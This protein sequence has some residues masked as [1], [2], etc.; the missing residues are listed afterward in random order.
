M[1]IA[2]WLSVCK[3]LLK[4]EIS[5]QGMVGHI[6]RRIHL[7]EKP[8]LNK[9]IGS[10]LL[11]EPSMFCIKRDPRSFTHFFS[12]LP[13][14]GRI[15]SIKYGDMKWPAKA[16]SETLKAAMSYVTYGNTESGDID[17]EPDGTL[18]RKGA[19]T[20]FEM[21]TSKDGRLLE[22]RQMK[23]GYAPLSDTEGFG[24][25]WMAL[26]E[27][28]DAEVISSGDVDSVLDAVLQEKLLTKSGKSLIRQ[29]AKSRFRDGK[30]HWHRS[31]GDHTFLE[32]FLKW[33]IK[34]FPKVM[35]VFA[36]VELYE[37]KKDGHTWKGLAAKLRERLTKSQD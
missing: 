22:R 19:E 15:K 13:L 34:K 33:D 16:T 7:H 10:M 14:G 17:F 25:L 29:I 27:A 8:R 32:H 30:L 11:L 6:D 21:F 12:Q 37:Q 26:S 9:R 1:I 20:H 4:E 35:A 23:A 31:F 24:D 2:L 36:D 18:W 28:E 3:A 5:A